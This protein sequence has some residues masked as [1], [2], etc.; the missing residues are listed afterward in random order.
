MY[1]IG[2]T[3]KKIRISK[4]LTLKDASSGIMAIST[5]SEF[6]SGKRDMSVQNFFNL[7]KNLN[8]TL[9]E[10]EYVSKDYNKDSFDKIWKKALEYA[11]S[12]NISGLRGL[13][14]R[15]NNENNGTI[16]YLNKLRLKNLIAKHDNTYALFQRERKFIYDYLIKTE[17]W[18]KF[19]LT[20]YT[21]VLDVFKA[22]TVE[23]LSN[24]IY[25]KSHHFEELN[26]NKQL[27][28]QLLIN[29]IAVMLENDRIDSAIKYQIYVKNIITDEYMFEK[30]IL[31][32]ASGV[33]E[34][35]KGNYE[36]GEKQMLDSIKIFN[37]LGSHNLADIYEKNY[38]DIIKKLT[39]KNE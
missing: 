17:E 34:Y 11:H 12:N 9:E 28:I 4:N 23:G 14:K 2:P 24:Q 16:D 8:L 3:I 5:L 27:I 15:L 37:T 10:F 33:I 6:E 26:E 7:V 29:S 13:Y 35:K 30:N 20:L 38:H 22:D 39:K 19:E 31:L 32:F 1:N 25:A 21:A 18:M 36:N